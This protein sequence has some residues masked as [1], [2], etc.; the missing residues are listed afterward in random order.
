MSLKRLRA[1]RLGRAELKLRD[2]E[3]H[4]REWSFGMR[5][6]EEWRAKQRIEKA[7]RRVERLK[8]CAR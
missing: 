8:G 5:P 3:W 1:R 2:A 4:L 7:Q 6:S